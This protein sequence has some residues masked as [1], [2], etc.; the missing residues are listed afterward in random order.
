HLASVGPIVDLRSGTLHEREEATRRAIQ[1]AKPA[2]LYHGVLRRAATISGHMCE[3]VGEPDFIFVSDPLTPV[4]IRDCKMA[5]RINEDDHP[6]ILR[7][8]ELY[9]WLFEDVSREARFKLEVLR[10]DSQLVEIAY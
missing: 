5:K 6:E 10:G 2:I 7:Q 3:I 4:V 8:L 9:G 1:N